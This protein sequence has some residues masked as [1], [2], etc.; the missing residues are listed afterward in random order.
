M[1]YYETVSY[2]PESGEFI[3]AVARRG[4]KKGA[5]AGHINA[6]GYRVIK[7][8]YRPILAHRLALFIANGVWPTG[9]IDHIN[10][11]RNDNRLA[12]LREVD[13]FINAQ[14]KRV[15]MANNESCGLLG[16]TWN[17]QH[18]RWQSKIVTNGKRTHVGY[19]S[20]PD[21]AHAAYLEAKRRLHAGCTI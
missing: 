5:T 15:A 6:E 10:G 17:K 18:K 16:V 19:F 2:D 3:W 1:N 14:N 13:A 12:N 21:E 8:G 7:L 9:P 4:C 11:V 20:Q